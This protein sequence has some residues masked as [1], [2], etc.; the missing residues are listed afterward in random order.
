MIRK[1]NDDKRTIA[2]LSI[3]NF[4]INIRKADIAK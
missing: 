2:F 3:H 1:C 4:I